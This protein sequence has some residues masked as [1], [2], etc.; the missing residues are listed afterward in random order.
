[1]SSLLCPGWAQHFFRYYPFIINYQF[2]VILF[3]L[4]IS[5]LFWLS[6]SISFG[7]HYHIAKVIQ[8][9]EN[10]DHPGI[11]TDDLRT[12]IDQLHHNPV[13]YQLRHLG[14]SQWPD[15]K[16]SILVQIKIQPYSAKLDIYSNNLL[17]TIIYM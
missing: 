6:V 2:L 16:Y 11:W 15:Y 9:D 12:A 13:H 3:N 4:F 7:F 17:E 8:I 10:V 1:M 14:Y 5:N